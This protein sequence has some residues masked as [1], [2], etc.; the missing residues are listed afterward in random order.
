MANKTN[1]RGVD[2][3]TDAFT[4]PND[5]VFREA[6]ERTPGQQV[7]YVDMDAARNI[8]RDK[9]RMARKESLEELDVAYFKAQ[10]L[11]QDTTAIVAAKQE[12]RDAP[13]DPRI[14][15]AQDPA[16]LKVVIPARIAARDME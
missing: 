8:W 16:E 12:L 2:Y 3:P 14:D 1:I 15:L 9:I 10:E 6:W 7:I 11:G 13:A 5:R 4:H